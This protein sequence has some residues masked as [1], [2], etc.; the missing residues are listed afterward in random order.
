MGNPDSALFYVPLEDGVVR[1]EVR[2]PVE[3]GW[4]VV[5]VS[6]ASCVAAAGVSAV[7]GTPENVVVRRGGTA[8]MKVHLVRRWGLWGRWMFGWRVCRG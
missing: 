6:A 8:V 5:S 1:L 4:G 7:Y 2:G 3:P